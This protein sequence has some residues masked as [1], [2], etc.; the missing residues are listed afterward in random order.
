M[1]GILVELPTLARPRLSPQLPRVSRSAAISPYLECMGPQW[2]TYFPRSTF[3]LSFLDKT[4]HPPMVA[5]WPLK[6]RRFPLKPLVCPFWIYIMIS[7]KGQRDNGILSIYVEI[8][9]G[10]QD[11]TSTVHCTVYSNTVRLQPLRRRAS[12][13][14]PQIP[15]WSVWKLILP[16]FFFFF[17]FGLRHCTK[18]A[19]PSLICFRIEIENQKYSIR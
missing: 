3:P 6:F 15:D 8:H 16:F 11:F 7:S 9:Q 4:K 13:H 12:L 10:S 5:T 14:T 19:P 1:R 18:K 17:F 2:R